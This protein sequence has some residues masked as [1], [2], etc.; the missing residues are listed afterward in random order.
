MTY[1]RELELT[2]DRLRQLPSMRLG[3]AESQVYEVLDAM[4]ERL[5]PRL[6]PL[7]WGDQLLVVGRDVP[8]ELRPLLVEPLRDLRRRFDLTL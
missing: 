4:T 2:A 8:G 7:A 1:D 6:R 5:V 3:P